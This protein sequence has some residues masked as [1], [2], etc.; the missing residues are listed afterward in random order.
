MS[1]VQITLEKYSQKLKDTRKWAIWGKIIKEGS[2]K[3]CTASTTWVSQ[4]YLLNDPYITFVCLPSYKALGDH[5][6]AHESGTSLT[7]FAIGFD[8]MDRPASFDL[9]PSAGWKE[10]KEISVCYCGW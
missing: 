5:W 10:L 2:I 6:M 4:F 8:S 7:F 3:R 9:Q 1:A